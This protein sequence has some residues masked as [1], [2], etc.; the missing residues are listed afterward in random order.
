MSFSYFY[1]CAYAK[2]D[3]QKEY[4]PPWR[5]ACAACPWPWPVRPRRALKMIKRGAQRIL[6]PV[7]CKFLKRLCSS[8]KNTDHREL[9]E[10]RHDPHTHTHTP[11]GCTHHM[12]MHPGCHRT[13]S[14]YMCD[15]YAEGRLQLA[16]GLSAG[17]FYQGPLQ[18]SMFSMT[19]VLSTRFMMPARTLPGP[20]S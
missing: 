18:T 8:V 16:S 15:I 13:R 10:T 3:T 5:A 4:I 11:H 14:R 9:S 19:L 1:I 17:R 7:M 20:S 6:S 12:H 2:N